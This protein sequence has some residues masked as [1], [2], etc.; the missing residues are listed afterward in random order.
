MNSP[1]ISRSVTRKT[2]IKRLYILL[3]FIVGISLLTKAQDIPEP[4]QPRRIVNDFT[5][6]FSKLEQ[7]SLER[8]LRNFNDS[9][10]TQIAV[11]VVPTL[12][13][14]DINDYAARLGEKWGVGQKGKDNGIILLVKPKTNRERGEVAISV[15]YG[16]EGVIPDVIAS[17]IIRNE[18]IPE[19]Q[20]DKY[21]RGVDKALTVLM[22]LSKGEYTADEY[23]KKSEG[24]IA[25][26]IIGFIIF[27]VLLLLVFRRRG[28]GGY[29]PGHSSGG[30]FFIFPMGGF[31]GGSSSGG[32]G[33]FSSGG[34]SF[35][36]FGGGSFGGGGSSGSW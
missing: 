20:Q 5:G 16:L 2:M 33:G 19:F 35:G 6:L 1:T 17:R 32:F 7:A 9:T 14:Y 24:G 28:G 29:S 27:A 4:M 18:I 26:F 31:G 10:S 3:A 21:Y 30:G 22:D 11:V 36:G 23:K 12:N 8:K 25:D 15:G 13:G 34:G